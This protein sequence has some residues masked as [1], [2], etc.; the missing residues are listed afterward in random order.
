VNIST[1]DQKIIDVLT[2]I[3]WESEVRKGVDNLDLSIWAH[4]IR[5][6]LSTLFWFELYQTAHA[7]V[8]IRSIFGIVFIIGFCF[9]V[10]CFLSVCSIF[11]TTFFF[12]IKKKLLEIVFPRSSPNPERLKT[13]PRFSKTFFLVLYLFMYMML[14][15]P[16]GFWFTL[17]ALF[18]LLF[19]YLVACDS[20]PP[21]KRKKIEER[22]RASEYI[23]S[24]RGA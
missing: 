8:L 10:S 7:S 19:S 2:A 23:P 14:H 20:L 1:L 11:M 17:S 3:C 5:Q 21:E 16:A 4:V 9:Y 13:K 24:P 15:T 18:S 6:I 22:L 12:K